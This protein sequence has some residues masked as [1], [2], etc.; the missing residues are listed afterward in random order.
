MYVF[1]SQNDLEPYPGVTH[2]HEDAQ[3]FTARLKQEA[4]G[5]IWLFGGGRLATALSD[6]GLVDE[7][8]IAVQPVLLGEGIPL[9]VAPHAR[10]DL[11][12]VRARTWEHGIVELRYRRRDA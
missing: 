6:A 4:G 5:A 9:W 10:T 8:L 11:E 3:R 7:Y 2:V 1:T 12:L